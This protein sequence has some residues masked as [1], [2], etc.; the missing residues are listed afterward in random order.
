MFSFRTMRIAEGLYLVFFISD[1]AHS[2]MSSVMIIF[3]TEIQLPKKIGADT[4]VSFFRMY[5]CTKRK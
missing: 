1:Y 4:L 5:Y 3:P 2:G